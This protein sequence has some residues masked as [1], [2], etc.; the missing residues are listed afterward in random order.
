MGGGE[1]GSTLASRLAAERKDVTLIDASEARCRELRESADIQVICGSGAQPGVLRSGGLENVDMLIA[2][3]GSDEV[4]LIAC[5]VAAHEAVIPTKIARVRDPDLAEAVPGIFGANP[6]DL[7]INPEEV[8]ARDM[9]KVLRVPGA[10]GV[11]EFADG[12]VQ[13][14]CFAIDGPCEAAGVRLSDLRPKLGAECN[15]VAVARNGDLLIPDG[16]TDLREGDRI[17]AAGQP[18]AQRALAAFVGKRGAAPRSV[19]INGGGNV[20]YYLARMLEERELAPKIIEPRS[21]RCKFLAERLERSVVIQGTASDPSLLLEEGIGEADVF[22]SLTGQDEENVLSGLIARRAGVSRV[23]SLINRPSYT[24]LVPTLGIDA[25]VSPNL[26]AVSAILQFIRRGK[27]LSVTTIADGAA[28]ALEIV[29]LETSEI[30]GRPL[31]DVGF[32][33]AVVGAIVRGEQ[34][35]IPSGDDEIGTGDRVVLFALRSAIPALERQMM[36]KLEYF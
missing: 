14:V 30:V 20:A 26:A 29:A 27:V 22:V 6:L 36:V 33:D 4:N 5:L 1:I 28:E 31:R 15:I 35:I 16:S 21:E 8:A 24:G 25:V 19:V 23:V 13:V 3:T 17:Y 7:T 2:V 10:A 11:F 34:V 12:R 9:L 32:R 18:D